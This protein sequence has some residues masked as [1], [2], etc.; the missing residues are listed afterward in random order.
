MGEQV[1]QDKL[2]VN[3]TTNQLLTQGE[4]QF[5]AEMGPLDLDYG[6]LEVNTGYSL[7]GSALLEFTFARRSNDSGDVPL[8]N[9]T[10]FPGL[11]N[12]NRTSR[13]R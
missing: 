1:G 13:T 3:I 10:L 7:N 5:S 12:G 8:Q 4:A 9:R 2:R 11:R 6:S